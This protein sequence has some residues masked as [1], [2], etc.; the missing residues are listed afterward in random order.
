MNK[1]ENYL[2][3]VIFLI[4]PGVF[5]NHNVIGKSTSFIRKNVLYL[6]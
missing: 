6:S 5:K 1:D 4:D 3:I 2:N